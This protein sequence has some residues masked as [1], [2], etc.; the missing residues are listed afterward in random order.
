MGYELFLQGQV[1]HRTDVHA[2]YGG[3]DQG[4]VLPDG[5]TALIAAATAMTTAGQQPVVFQNVIRPNIQVD[6]TVS[7]TTPSATCSV[8]LWF[9]SPDA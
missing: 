1:Y 8:D 5:S 6:W 4:S 2:R 7:G 9:T 3:Q